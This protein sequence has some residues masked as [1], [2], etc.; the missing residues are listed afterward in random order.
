ML[1]SIDVHRSNALE[2]RLTLCRDIKSL[3]DLKISGFSIKILFKLSALLLIESIISIDF[4]FDQI[5]DF[6]RYLLRFLTL[7]NCIIIEALFGITSIGL[8]SLF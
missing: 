5:V 1:V 8:I 7:F 6:F 2:L 3:F 4:N